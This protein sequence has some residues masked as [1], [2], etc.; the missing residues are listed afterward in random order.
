L[1]ESTR[2][3][4]FHGEF[5]WSKLKDWNSLYMS[6][7]RFHDEKSALIKVKIYGLGNNGKW[8]IDRRNDKSTVVM[9]R[10]YIIQIIVDSEIF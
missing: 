10:I 8:G 5:D 9:E 6:L 2:R 4:T 7:C 3:R 1:R